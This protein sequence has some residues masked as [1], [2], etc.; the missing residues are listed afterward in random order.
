MPTIKHPAS[1]IVAS[2]WNSLTIQM[3]ISKRILDQLL[4]ELNPQQRNANEN[5]GS[6]GK[7]LFLRLIM[8]VTALKE[9][10]F[11]KEEFGG[12]LHDGQLPLNNI[13][14]IYKI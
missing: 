13:N 14:A 7:S 9:M 12:Q 2:L 4:V 10:N 1:R 5:R 3:A 11:L 8:E 6:S